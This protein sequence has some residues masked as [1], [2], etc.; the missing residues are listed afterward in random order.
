MAADVV[1]AAAPP[2]GG[3]LRGAAALLLRD[4]PD[5]R[6]SRAVRARYAQHRFY[7]RTAAARAHLSERP[8]RRALCRRL[9]LSARHEPT[10]PRLCREP[11]QARDAAL[12]LPW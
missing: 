12:F 6:V 3:G 11:R 10:A 5:Q 2:G 7:L 9:R 1:A 8:S 4:D